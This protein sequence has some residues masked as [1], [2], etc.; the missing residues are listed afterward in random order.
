VKRSEALRSLS[1]DHHHALVVGRLLSEA[2]DT[3][4]ATAAFL[5]FWSDEGCRH[6]RI[7]EEVL[8]PAWEMLGRVDRDA[9]SRLAQEHR[10][11]RAQAL[12]L[13]ERGLSL[14]ELQQLGGELS[15]HVRFEERE[16]FP[17]IEA[18]LEPAA[19]ER[20]ASMVESADIDQ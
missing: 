20:L 1:R 10:L 5:D 15:A 9:A 11:I 16:L 2:K 7:E 17:L 18:D 12:R 19:L 14:P 3:N 4:E 8:L 6:F 13:Q